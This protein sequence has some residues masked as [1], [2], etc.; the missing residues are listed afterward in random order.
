VTL[1]R[2]RVEPDLWL[3]TSVRFTGKGRALLVRS[4]D[5]DQVIEWTNYRRVP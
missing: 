4:L 1:T 5:I 2:E 3:P